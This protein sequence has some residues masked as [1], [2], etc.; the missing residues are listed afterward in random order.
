MFAQQKSQKN[1]TPASASSSSM[2]ESLEGRQLFSAAPAGS[3]DTDLAAVSA[4]KVAMQDFHFVMRSTKASP[5]ARVVFTDVLVSS[6]GA[7]GADAGADAATTE[8][9]A[10][11]VAMQDFSFTMKVNKASPKL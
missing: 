4:G 9:S 1:Q 3:V 10:G 7:A 8:A 6:R 2:I 5:E 11:K